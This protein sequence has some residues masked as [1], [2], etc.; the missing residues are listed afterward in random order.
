MPPHADILQWEGLPFPRRLSDFQRL[1]CDDAACARWLE[2]AKWPTGFV[3]PHCGE[4]GDPVRLDS[5]PGVLACRQCRKQTSITVGTVMERTHS[6]LTVWFC[7]AYLLRRDPDMTVKEFQAHLRL[8]SY[9][10]AHRIWSLLRRRRMENGTERERRNRD[11][12]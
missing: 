10:T 1:F 8:T 6:P 9:G 12:A 2:G 7:A 3:C 11:H 4:K 5:R